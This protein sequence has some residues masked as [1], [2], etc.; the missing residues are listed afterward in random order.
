MKSIEEILN[1]AIRIVEPSKEERRRVD[2]IA[3]LTMKLIKDEASKFNEVKDI[4]FGGSYAKDTWLPNDVD[5]D[6]FIKL[7]E[8]VDNNRFEFIGKSIGFNALKDYNPYLRYSQHPYVECIINS[9]KINLVPCYDVELGKWKSAAD[10]SRYHTEFINKHFDYYKRREVRLLKKFMKA[11]DVYGAEIKVNGFSGYV[12]E[13][14]ILKYNTFINLLKNASKFK[15]KEVISI[16]ECD[17]SILDL[18]NSTLIIID[19]IDPKR[20]LGSAIS[21]TS[22]AKFILASREFLES[23]SI[24]YFQKVEDTSNKEIDNIL[25]IRFK[26]SKKSEDIIWGEAK[27]TLKSLVKQLNIHGFSVIRTTINI[28]N[29]YI[30][31]GLLLETLRLPLYYL[32]IGPKIF[33]EDNINKFIKVN[34]DS[35]MLWIDNDRVLSLQRRRYTDAYQLV[36]DL[37]SAKVE[38]IGIAKGLINDIKEG[39][40]I[41]SNRDHLTDR[42]IDYL[43]STSKLLRG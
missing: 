29:E 1:N 30:T 2:N 42:V 23:P 15:E 27:H 9:I 38:Q 35:L 28:C 4:L 26:Y 40:E 20:N 34:R 11:I 43:T 32:K 16:Y 7:D 37:L 21:N 10:R 5:I 14:L 31:F 19:P 22:V 33:D 36:K 8:S 18:F 24:R 41:Y 17:K 25:I 3:E 12:C 13:V 39:F 6:I